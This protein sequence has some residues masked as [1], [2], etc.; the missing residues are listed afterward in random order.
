MEILNR[1]TLTTMH[2]LLAVFILPAAIMFFITGALYTWGVKGNYDT[3]TYELHL[4]KPIQ[5]EL[6]GLVA[7]AKQE[8][9]KKDLGEPS[10]QAKIKKIGSSFKLEWTGSNMDVIIE[11]TSQPLIAKLKVKNTSWHRQFVQLHKA[12]GGIPFKVYAAAFSIALLLLL[13]SGFIMAWQM[14]KLRKLV[15]VSVSLGIV[16]FTVM[17]VSS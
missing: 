15:L 6:D 10:G 12:K 3:N 2:A 16:M 14:P 17:V 8:L 13:T 7:L 4:E 1:S 11:P 9:Q 5:S